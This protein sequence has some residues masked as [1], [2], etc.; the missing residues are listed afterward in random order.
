MTYHYTDTLVLSLGPHSYGP[1][2]RYA[3]SGALL[4][5]C[6]YRSASPVFNDGVLLS[7]QATNEM[8]SIKVVFLVPS[9]Y[10]PCYVSDLGDSEG[11]KRVCVPSSTYNA[12]NR[13]P[14]D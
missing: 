14:K 4:V 11:D 1:L 8:S 10:L 12:C 3:T 5:A 13:R 9:R 2:H 6:H 7:R